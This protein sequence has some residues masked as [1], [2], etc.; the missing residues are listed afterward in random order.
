MHRLQC[1]RPCFRSFFR[2]AA[3]GV[4]LAAGVGVMGAAPVNGLRYDIHMTVTTVNAGSGQSTRAYDEGLAHA[5]II[6]GKSRVDVAKGPIGVLTDGEFLI[7]RDTTT[8]L[9]DPQ[10]MQYAQVDPAKMMQG[11]SG[12]IGGLNAMMGVQATNVKVDEAA[13][14]AGD[15]LGTFSTL[16]YRITEDYAVTLNV[17]GMG[18]SMTGHT[19][20]DY[21]FAQGGPPFVNP[22][23]AKGASPTQ[24]PVNLGP[25]YA[26]QM[27]AARAKLPAG[28]PVKTVVVTLITDANGNRTTTTTTWELTNVVIAAV[29]DGAF[30]TPAGYSQLTGPEAL[31]TMTGGGAAGAT[32]GAA[33]ATA[34]STA[35]A[36]P[37]GTS[38]GVGGAAAG[39]AGGV[40][41]AAKQGAVSGVTGAV[42]G[43]ASS[44]TSG[45]VSKILHIP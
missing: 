27:A 39:A 18:S 8:L 34:P 38:S 23:V 31:M 36:R 24:L 22:F 42:S 33:A 32:P 45:A 44:A 19:T 21:W 12:V 28:V 15:K 11:L 20:T 16:K 26:A 13:L 29:P 40:G 10:K 4:A 17:M 25:Q 6:P 14:G 41:N 30:D 35:A 1:E 37:G 43:A 9:F 7:T 3:V 5:Q 2:R